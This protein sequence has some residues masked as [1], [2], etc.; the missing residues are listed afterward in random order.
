MTLFSDADLLEMLTAAGEQVTVG[1]QSI[2]G[3]FRDD[4]DEA[5]DVEGSALRLTCR[6]SDV[7]AVEHGTAATVRGSDYTVRGIQGGTTGLTVLVL[8]ET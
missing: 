8:E 2:Y 5:L 7:A 6:T 3:I 4:Y 1:G